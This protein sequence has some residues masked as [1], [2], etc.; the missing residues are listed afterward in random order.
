MLNLIACVWCFV[1][2]FL[3]KP[4][5]DGSY[6]PRV[7]LTIALGVINGLFFIHSIHSGGN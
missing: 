6:R 4:N 7:W 5:E 2:V 3:S 1:S